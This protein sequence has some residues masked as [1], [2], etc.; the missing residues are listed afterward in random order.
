LLALLAAQV[1]LG[2]SNI[3][4]GLPLFVAVLHNL[5]GALLLISTAFINVLLN[6]KE[7]NYV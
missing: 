4:F 3:V 1:T 6:R 2:I 5:G 7:P